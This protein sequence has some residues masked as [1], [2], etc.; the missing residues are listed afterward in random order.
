MGEMGGKD[1][2]FP[3]APLMILAAVL[4]LPPGSA[5]PTT[6]D[7]TPPTFGGIALA[8]DAGLGGAV[9]VGWNPAQDPDTPIQYLV[10][11]ARVG[12][13]LNYSTPLFSTFDA[14]TVVG[15]LTD[16]TEYQF[17]ARAMDA[18]GKVDANLVVR[19]ATPTH[20][21]DS[22]PP[23]FTGVGSVV[24]L[25]TGSSARVSGQPAADPDT[26]ESSSDPSLPIQ[27]SVYFSQVPDGLGVGMPNATT[28]ATSVD[29][30]GLV[31]GR[32]Y[33]VLVRAADAAGNME[34]NTRIVSFQI[35]TPWWSYSW[36]GA[37][38]GGGVAAAL[39]VYRRRRKERPQPATSPN[40]TAPTEA[41]V[42]KTMNEDGGG[43]PPP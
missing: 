42:R 27:H 43:R 12:Q 26:P 36:I 17:A 9:F 19:R 18:T 23:S 4:F 15:G 7:A 22:T 38:V 40:G 16:G 14:F 37:A 39:L 32:T 10:F 3:W 25:G 13:S 28:R 41:H 30:G 35:T 2:V 34:N 8:A 24:D 21:Y 11:V 29:I 33:Y 31:Q 5:T 1:G 20:P 6:S